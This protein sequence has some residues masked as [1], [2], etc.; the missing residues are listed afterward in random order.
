MTETEEFSYSIGK[1]TISQ[2]QSMEFVSVSLQG[3]TLVF[4]S[5]HGGATADAFARRLAKAD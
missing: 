5:G 2:G 3:V 4:R 1:M